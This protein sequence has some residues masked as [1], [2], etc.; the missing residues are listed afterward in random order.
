MFS[1][2]GTSPTD[3]YIPRIPLLCRYVKRVCRRDYP[4]V[5]RSFPVNWCP[6]RIHP[7][8]PSN[9][10]SGCTPCRRRLPSGC[11]QAQCRYCQHWTAPFF[12]K[13]TAFSPG[14][15]RNPNLSAGTVNDGDDKMVHV[16]GFT[17]LPNAGNPFGYVLFV[18]KRDGQ[19]L[20]FGKTLTRRQIIR[21]G[22]FVHRHQRTE[23]RNVQEPEIVA[24]R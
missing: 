4:S 16:V 20:S 18:I 21:P 14:C 5:N 12:V 3:E 17:R 22:G 6:S 9:C 11:H 15:L 13:T 24:E 1:D 23:S 2:T 8:R 19:F 7:T 10:L